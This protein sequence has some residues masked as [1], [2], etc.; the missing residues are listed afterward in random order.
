[1]GRTLPTPGV[2]L[3]FFSDDHFF[4]SNIS[5]NRISD[6]RMGNHISD[7]EIFPI[8]TYFRLGHSAP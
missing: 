1:M 2:A 6:K 3:R 8:F 5:D 7:M 4:D